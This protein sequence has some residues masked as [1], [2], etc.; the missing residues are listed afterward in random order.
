MTSGEQGSAGRSPTLEDVAAAAGV[1]R[2]TAS[3]AINGGMRVSA[4]AQAAVDAAVLS[5]RFTP[6]RAA[7]ALVTQRTNA[8]ALVI[9]EPDD[10]VT[11]DPGH[12]GSVGGQR[13][14]NGAADREARWH[15]R[16]DDPV[17]AARSRRRRRCGLPPR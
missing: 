15:G 14:P 3:R 7:R 16:A 8:V 12:G 5:L 2:S 11:G 4:D 17:P 13:L 6:N 10:R 1:S 9:A